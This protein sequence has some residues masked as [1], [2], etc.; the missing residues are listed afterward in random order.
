MK[1]WI[2]AIGIVVL[3]CSGVIGVTVSINVNSMNEMCNK[4]ISWKNEVV[5]PLIERGLIINNNI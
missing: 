5:I 2:I 1:K 3:I 4:V